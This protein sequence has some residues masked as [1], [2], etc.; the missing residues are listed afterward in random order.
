M[1]K[2][3]IEIHIGKK[4]VFFSIICRSEEEKKNFT[5]IFFFRKGKKSLFFRCS[6][7]TK[8]FFSPA[9]SSENSYFSLVYQLLLLFSLLFSP[10]FLKP[11]E[12]LRAFSINLER[13]SER[14]SLLGFIFP[15]FFNLA[16]RQSKIGRLP[17]YC[18]KERSEKNEGKIFFFSSF[19]RES[20]H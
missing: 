5:K 9:S 12:N 19:F 1:N 7:R 4:K 17:I 15:E 18:S 20:S 10:Q 11:S 3:F 8:N 16:A 6:E 14:L 13:A 2:I